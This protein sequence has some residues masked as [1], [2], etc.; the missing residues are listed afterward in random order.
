MQKNACLAKISPV[1]KFNFQYQMISIAVFTEK[2]HAIAYTI[3]SSLLG[4]NV[5]VIK[6]I[7]IG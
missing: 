6:S 5:H 4:S 3:F 1:Q 2:W 7:K